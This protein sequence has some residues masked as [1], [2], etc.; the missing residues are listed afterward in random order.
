MSAAVITAVN[1]V[2]DT[3]VVVRFDPFHWTTDPPTKL[4]PLIVRTKSVPPAAVEAGLR[5]F[6]FGGGLLIVSVDA[7]EVPPPG[8]DVN[9][10]TE[11]IPAAA[12]SE[13]GIATVK[14]DEETY[15]VIRLSPFHCT[16]E[17]LMK[18]LPFTVSV[19]AEPP[20]VRFDGL[21][22]EIVGAGGSVIVKLWALEVPPPGAG[23]NT[24]T[25]AVPAASMS[26]AGIAAVN[27][28]DETY[29]VVRSVPFHWITE[30]DLKPLPLTVS[31]KAAL[32]E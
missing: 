30:L 20:T 9:T 27:R 16:I 7:L 11:T 4:L 19:K 21:K 23:L 3:N 10:V 2:E 29:V 8:A 31:V 26:E 6:K 15:V 18:P 25:L 14:R 5:L 22:F 17:S 1:L 13:A 12:M 32:P 24:V 28:V